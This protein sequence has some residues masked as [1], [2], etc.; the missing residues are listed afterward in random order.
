MLTNRLHIISLFATA[1]IVSATSC[2]ITSQSAIPK[3]NPETAASLAPVATIDMSPLYTK[4]S[5]NGGQ[6]F[7]NVH[8][9]TITL[10]DL[11]SQTSITLQAPNAHLAFMSS[12]G[13]LLVSTS[14]TDPISI[15]DLP[16]P[17]PKHLFGPYGSIV[18]MAFSEDSTMLLAL[19][20]NKMI[21][22]WDLATDD[23]IALYDFKSWPAQNR[24][25]SSIDLSPDSSHFAAISADDIPAIKICDLS[26]PNNC[27]TIEW[28]QSARQFYAV[29]FN[30]NWT[31][32]AFISGASA[33]LFDISTNKLGPLLTHEDAISNWRF[34]PDGEI[35]AIY[36]A[37]TINQHYAS[38]IKLWD[39]STGDNTQTFMRSKYAHA[40]TINPQ[41]TH[42]ATSS[43]TGYIHIWDID[44]GKQEAVYSNTDSNTEYLSLAYSPDGKLLAAV[45]AN[46]TITLWDTKTHQELSSSSV[47]NIS[48]TTLD[49]SVN[50]NWITTF[51]DN[52][53]VTIWKP[54]DS[55]R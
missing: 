21:Y 38:L 24:H 55:I 18:S 43:D 53:Y 19:D 32:L 26:N 49:F 17:T 7:A 54:S 41:G 46:G 8:D 44:S 31:Q 15:W 2:T 4:I 40:T 11:L 28:P 42:I 6:Y 50:G 27:R 16:N 35:L 29:E 39:T 9:Q 47:P 22:L 48:P 52:D 20:T 33:Q 37:G 30:T 25:I 13:K 34:T 5:A 23:L 10:T 1:L 45:D 14:Y 36:T 12:S 51:S 3:L